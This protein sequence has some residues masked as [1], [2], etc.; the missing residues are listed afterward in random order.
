MVL[1]NGALA[2]GV[3]EVHE[4]LNT[5]DTNTNPLRRQDDQLHSHFREIPW[6]SGVQNRHVAGNCLQLQTNF[7]RFGQRNYGIVRSGLCWKARQIIC[8]SCSWCHSN[9]SSLASLKSRTAYPGFPEKEAAK[10]VFVLMAA[11]KTYGFISM[12]QKKSHLSYGHLKVFDWGYAE[13]QKATS[14]VSK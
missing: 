12:L 4:L 3:A 8:T 11:A 9:T 2:V 14:L 5:L 7:Q 6:S 10:W 1:L 13:R